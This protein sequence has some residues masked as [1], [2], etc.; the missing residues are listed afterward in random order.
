MNVRVILGIAQ[1]LWVSTLAEEHYV[2]TN[3]WKAH[4][5]SGSLSS[6]ALG[7]DGVIYVGTSEGYL[8]ALNPAGL[9]RWRFK[10]GVEI[11]SSPAIAI[12]GTVYVG[13]RDRNLYAVGG[14][15]HKRWA[16]KTG[17]WV[18]ASA[19]I[20]ED[21]TIYFGSWDKNFYALTPEGVKKW[22]FATGGPVVSSAAIGGD[23]VIYFGSHDR[24]FYA[25]NPE[26]GKRWEYATQGAIL[27]S[28]AIA[29]D[30]ALYFTSVDGK[31][32]AV[33]ADGTRRWVLATGG[34]TQASPV[35]G[36]DGTIYVGVN[37]H[38]CAISAE[39][40]LKWQ[41]SLDPRGHVP[42]DWIGSTPAVLADGSALTSGTDGVITTFKLNGDWW[43]YSL[44]GSSRA[45]PVVGRDGTV[46][47]ASSGQDLHAIRNSV[48][49][50]TTPWPMF[51]GNPQH[52]GRAPTAP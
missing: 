14:S 9:V 52:T 29:K 2:A 46:Y 47:G 32:H 27:S 30:G 15:G 13:C 49:L 40:K 16:F 17:G 35:I 51:R 45:S 50:A 37:D 23:G 42:F 10:T 41:R 33:N 19:A 48:P 3:L 5:G 21:G 20:A 38:H 24:K 28:P 31:F 11:A 1:L 4:T 18:D 7:H 25:L 43:I 39:G 12:G 8:I 26:G 36:L 22:Q 34:I 6:P 44:Q